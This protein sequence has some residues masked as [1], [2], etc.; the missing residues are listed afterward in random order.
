MSED[1]AISATLI[2]PSC[3]VQAQ[4]LAS[5]YRDW[6]D[7][8]GR[9]LHTTSVVQFQV[10]DAD[11]PYEYDLGLGYFSFVP[12]IAIASWRQSQALPL[13]RRDQSR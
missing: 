5:T 7:I 13:P 10:L 3:L 6:R 8:T 9:V 4:D 11:H 12:S 1:P 2:V